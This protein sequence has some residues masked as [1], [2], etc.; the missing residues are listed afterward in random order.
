VNA[1]E[2]ASAGEA[3]LAA[4]GD[5]ASCEVPHDRETAELLEGIGGTVVAL[6]DNVYPDGTAA[7]YADCY[8]RTWGRHKAR[9]RP[10]PGNHEYETSNA[11]PYYEYFGAAAGPPGRGYY[12]YRAGAWQVLSLNSEVPMR[13]G[14]AQHEWLRSELE[15]NP[16]ACTIAYFHRPLFSSGPNGDQPDVRPLWQLLY[17]YRADIIVSGHDHLY[18]RYGLQDPDG[19]PDAAAGI[20]QFIVGT[21][22]GD[23][24]HLLRSRPTSEARGTDWGVLK[25]TLDTGAYAW[26]FIPVAGA[27]F[28]DAG[29]GVCR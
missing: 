20:R 22:G 28:R 17:E 12:A 25:L 18:E 3:V 2:G 24:Y 5:I 9:T 21:G 27:S 4:A 1:P 13:P 14:S 19:R 7:E 16:S 8:E 6:G 15:D 10:A 29:T 23:R 11:A 26:E